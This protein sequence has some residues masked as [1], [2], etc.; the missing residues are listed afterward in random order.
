[1]WEP[2]QSLDKEIIT[3]QLQREPRNLHAIAKR[4]ANQ[5]PNVIVN[6]PLAKTTHDDLF[7]PTLFWLTCP[8]LVK[9]ISQLEDKGLIHDLQK[10]IHSG[11]D[12]SER[13]LHAQQSYIDARQSLLPFR[14][15]CKIRKLNP[16]LARQMESKGIG[17]VE[18]LQTIKC[19]HMHYAH[20]VITGNN[21]VGAFVSHWLSLNAASFTCQQCPKQA[22][23]A[24]VAELADAADLKSAGPQGSCRFDSGPRHQCFTD[25]EAPRS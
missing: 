7:F 18:N 5:C 22:Q 3:W 21:P 23:L 12:L 16:A 13:L 4:C 19:L 8:G 1:M 11:S 14:K 25:G 9:Q 24:G 10:E 6:F 17:G 2:L 15:R 20:H